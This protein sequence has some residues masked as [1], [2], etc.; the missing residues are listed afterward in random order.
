MKKLNDFTKTP[1][2]RN[3]LPTL[4]EKLKYSF[5]DVIQLGNYENS[6][7]ESLVQ[8]ATAI[9]K[10]EEILWKLDFAKQVRESMGTLTDTLPL[11][12]IIRDL[13]SQLK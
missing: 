7:S 3:L 12:K 6:L 11:D 2:T 13:E 8:K 9:L 1:E 5:D 10:K 4:S